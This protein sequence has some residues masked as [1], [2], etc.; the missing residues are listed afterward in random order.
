M[1]TNDLTGKIIGLAMEIHSTIG[2]GLLESVYKECL[3]FKAKKAGLRI[4]KEKPVPFIF[5]SVQLDCGFRLDLVVENKVVIEIKSVDAIHPIH[6]AQIL[7]YLKLGNY[8][9]GLL[10]NFNVLHMREGIKRI[11]L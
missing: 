10:F 7:T 11:I 3:F 9:V 4:E 2:P 6:I 8:R 1:E 5:E